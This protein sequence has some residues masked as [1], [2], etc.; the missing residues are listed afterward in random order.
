MWVMGGAGDTGHG[1]RGYRKLCGDRKCLSEIGV[2]RVGSP[3]FMCE[4]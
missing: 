1:P 3:I 2:V 4:L